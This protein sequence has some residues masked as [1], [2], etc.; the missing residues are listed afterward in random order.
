MIGSKSSCRN[1]PLANRSI[2]WPKIVGP[3][4]FEIEEIRFVVSS[5]RSIFAH[6]WQATAWCGLE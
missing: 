6:L 5:S 4:R 1:L 2:F 3:I